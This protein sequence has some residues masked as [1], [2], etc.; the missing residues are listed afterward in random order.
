MV[1]SRIFAKKEGGQHPSWVRKTSSQGTRNI[2]ETVSDCRA[3][4]LRPAQD[5]YIAEKQA[6]FVQRSRPAENRFMRLQILQF[7]K[8]IKHH[9]KEGIHIRLIPTQAFNSAAHNGPA[10]IHPHLGWRLTAGTNA[11]GP[12]DTFPRRLAVHIV[13]YIVCVW[14]GD[15]AGVMN[16]PTPPYATEMSRISALEL[17]KKT[18]KVII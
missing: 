17:K 14:L 16:Q 1:W 10:E 12:S 3:S 8:K 9:I 2:H 7:L 6:E 4:K 5:G 18:K 11:Y 15:M 13:L